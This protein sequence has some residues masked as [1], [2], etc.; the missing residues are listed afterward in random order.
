VDTIHTM[1]DVQAQSICSLI[2]YLA[3]PNPVGTSYKPGEVWLSIHD[4]WKY[5]FGKSKSILETGLREVCVKSHTCN[6]AGAS[7]V[8]CCRCL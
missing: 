5:K 6:D 1:S 3:V 8:P 4:W 7:R 2:L